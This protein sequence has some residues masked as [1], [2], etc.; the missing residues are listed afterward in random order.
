MLQ[1]RWE[2]WM[3]VVRREAPDQERV[4][5]SEVALRVVVV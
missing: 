2:W 3:V 5:Q 4:R 1:Q